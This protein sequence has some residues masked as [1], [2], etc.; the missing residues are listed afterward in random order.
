MKKND[1]IVLGILAAFLAGGVALMLIQRRE[2]PGIQPEHITPSEAGRYGPE[3]G[4]TAVYWISIDGMRPDYLERADTPF[5]DHLLAEGAYSLEHEV[6]FPPFT[7]PSHVSQATGVPVRDHGIPQNR[8]YDL[9]TGRRHDYPGDSRLLEAEP[10]WTTAARQ[11]LRVAS[12][13]W[14][15][16]HGQRGEHAAAYF[17]PEFPRGLSDDERLDRLLGIW[18]TDEHAE[19]LRLAMGYIGAPDSAGHGQ[20]PGS[21]AVIE[22]VEATDALL[23]RHYEAVVESWNRRRNPGDELYF[24]LTSDHGMSEVHTLIHPEHLTGLDGDGV[25]L[26]TGGNLAHVYFDSSLAPEDRNGIARAALDRLEEFAFL[27]AYTRETLPPEW[28]YDHPAR[29]GDLVVVLNPGYTFSRTPEGL[30]MPA[31]EAGGPFGMHGYDPREDPN[32]TT[33]A[34]FHRHPRPLGGIDL[35]PVHSLQLHPTVAGLLGIT[36]AEGAVSDPIELERR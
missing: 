11:G 1:L 7:F 12:L 33:I 6:V 27:R 31:E 28:G 21:D 26:L 3:N 15:L 34:L 5:F 13:G 22:A 2:P 8:F 17:D 19:P 25:T 23:E 14:V 4:V 36:P 24:I 35:G 18:T 20:G 10:I 9:D 32:M 30:S 29:T 16:A